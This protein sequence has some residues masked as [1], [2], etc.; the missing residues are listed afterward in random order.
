MT[1][2]GLKYFVSVKNVENQ[3]A[4]FTLE[5]KE[6]EIST[7]RKEGDSMH[8]DDCKFYRWYYD[9]CDKWNCKTDERSFCNAFE[10]RKKPLREIMV[11][12]S[13]QISTI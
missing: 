11:N 8:C 13:T 6:S 4:L 5:I 12:G 1:K 3:K 10:E 9:H 2:K 7:I